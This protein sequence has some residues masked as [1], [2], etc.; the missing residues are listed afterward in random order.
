MC[1]K[2]V[3]IVKLKLR[4]G[5]RAIELKELPIFQKPELIKN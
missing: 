4:G 1:R 5:K 3:F 2:A